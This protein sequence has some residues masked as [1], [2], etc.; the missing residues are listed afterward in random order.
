MSKCLGIMECEDKEYDPGNSECNKCIVN[1][2]ATVAEKL[3]KVQSVNYDI[4]FITE[5]SCDYFKR[6]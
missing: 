4:R 2:P 6:T 1:Y 5:I 3:S